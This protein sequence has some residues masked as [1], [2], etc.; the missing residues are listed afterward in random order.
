[1]AEIARDF[2]EVEKATKLTARDRHESPVNQEQLLN[3]AVSLEEAFRELSRRNGQREGMRGDYLH[4]AKQFSQLTGKS[5]EISAKE[6]SVLLHQIQE[7]CDACHD[8]H[9]N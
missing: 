1:M 3:R 9:R 6:R 5:L 4:I 7:R 2:E 8:A